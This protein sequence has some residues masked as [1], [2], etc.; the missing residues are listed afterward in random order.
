MVSL[1]SSVTF[2]SPSN[3]CFSTKARSELNLFN[4]LGMGNRGDGNPESWN[5]DIM[6]IPAGYLCHSHGKSPCY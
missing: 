6:D 1:R 2:P 4:G 5:I 3:P